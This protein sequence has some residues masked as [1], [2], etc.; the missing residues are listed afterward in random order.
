MFCFF[1][2]FELDFERDL[3][4]WLIWEIDFWDIL[5]TLLSLISFFADLGF[6][7][8]F[9]LCPMDLELLDLETDFYDLDLDLDLDFLCLIFYFLVK[10]AW[11]SE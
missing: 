9:L 4:F 8:F 5:D 11:T 7:S 3:D 1:E 10:L 6:F 2:I